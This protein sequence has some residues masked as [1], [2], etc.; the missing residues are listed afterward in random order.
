MTDEAPDPLL[1]ASELAEHLSLPVA[2]VWKLARD[3]RIP[4]YR[5]PGGRSLCRFSWPE[6]AAVLHQGGA[7]NGES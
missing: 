6:V 2:S 4:V 7:G 5:V 1:S 3:G